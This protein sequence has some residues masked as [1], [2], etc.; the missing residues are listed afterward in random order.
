MPSLKRLTAIAGTAAAAT[1]YIRR[2]PDKVNQAA[3]KAGEFIDK[4]TKGKYHDRIDN[5]VRKVTTK[6]SGKPDAEPTAEA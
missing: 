6:T 1:S 4:Q 5:V 2:H 3:T